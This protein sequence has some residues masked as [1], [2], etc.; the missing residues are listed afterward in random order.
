MV[1][2]V[3]SNYITPVSYTHL[4]V[5][6][7]QIFDRFYQIDQM[8]STDASKTGTGIGLALTKGIVEL[9]HGTIHNF[10][11]FSKSVVNLLKSSGFLL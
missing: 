3:K 4:D 2:N 6:K 11:S 8:D 10:A 9:H 1:L 5:Y 7:R